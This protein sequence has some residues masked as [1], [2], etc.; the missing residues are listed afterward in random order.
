MASR[1]SRTVS[2]VVGRLSSTRYAAPTHEVDGLP[3]LRAQLSTAEATRAEA[4]TPPLAVVV[5][6]L[7]D[8]AERL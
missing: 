6:E 8:V 7:D 4:L 3:L 2:E 5:A 1:P